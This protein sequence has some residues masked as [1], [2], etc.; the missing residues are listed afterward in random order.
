MAFAIR[1]E[2]PETALAYTMSEMR[3]WLDKHKVQPVQFN[4][5]RLETVPAIAF[6]VQ[7]R[8][9]EE[10]ALFERVFA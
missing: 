4:V 9:E 10:A 7:F 3:S 8:S 5:E 2:K 6:D 1:I